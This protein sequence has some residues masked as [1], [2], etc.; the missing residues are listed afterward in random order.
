MYQ[1]KRHAYIPV[2]WA[3]WLR[4][5]RERISFGDETRAT[6]WHKYYGYGHVEIV[7]EVCRAG[8]VQVTIG[9]AE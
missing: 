8:M 9:E 1:L 6:A 5:E 4:G 3:H 2:H 7:G